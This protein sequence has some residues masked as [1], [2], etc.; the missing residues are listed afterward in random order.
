MII[1]F[2]NIP[3]YIMRKVSL[4]RYYFVLYVG[5][6]TLKMSK[7]TLNP[8]CDKTLHNDKNNYNWPRATQGCLGRGG[9]GGASNIFLFLPEKKKLSQNR[10]VLSSICTWLQPAPLWYHGCPYSSLASARANRD[11]ID[12]HNG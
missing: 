4:E 12:L 8:F 11:S 7:M 2:K 9:G 3:L 5:A 6:L 1:N 10:V